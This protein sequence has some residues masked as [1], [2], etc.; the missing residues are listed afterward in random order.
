MRLR[1]PVCL[2]LIAAPIV[3][4]GCPRPGAVAQAVRPK[5]SVSVPG[6]ARCGVAKD[7]AE[8][9][10]VE[11]PSSV[12]AKLE[13]IAHNGLVAVRFQGC[14]L[15]VLQ[16]CKVPG[17][18]AWTPITRKE[19][20]VSM[21]DQDELW[22][23]VPIGA[24][25]L[26]GKLARSGALHV[27][28]TIVGRWAAD[29]DAIAKNELNGDCARVTHVVTG[30]VAGAFDF[31]AG[32]DATVAGGASVFNVGAGGKSA[33]SAELINRDGET[34]SC[35]K[36]T[37]GDKTPP[38]GC[39]ALLRIELSAVG[40]AKATSAT[41]DCTDK[42]AWDGKQCAALVAGTGVECPAGF[43]QNGGQCE[44][45]APAASVAAPQQTKICTYG[46]AIECTRFCDVDGDASSCNDLA[47]MLSRGDGVTM[48]DKKATTFFLRSCDLGSAIGCNNA[49]MRVEYGRG[50][51]K[52]EAHAGT[53]YEKACDRGMAAACNNLGR[54]VINGWGIA[55]DEPRA[56]DL[57]RKG[58]G[59]GDVGACANLGWCYVRGKGVAADRAAGVSFLKKACKG[60]NSW[61]CDRLTDLKE[62]L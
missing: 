24:G 48:D 60:G 62:P 9:L 5:P 57:F 18:Y 32:A 35:V 58:C 31:W 2:A 29:H 59:Q 52:D 8:P 39:G 12:R 50:V 45:I 30:M 51:N 6:E 7:H 42:T 11:W 23:N 21:R 19:D 53:L 38:D 15:E 3:A 56:V 10:I 43:A 27:K 41:P 47:L 22:A 55:K 37:N 28:M 25:G 20:R 26:E 36:S 14:E 44:K 54:M 40:A 33:S 49:G 61:S 34:S 4:T 13:A 17:A 16:H 1:V 46:D